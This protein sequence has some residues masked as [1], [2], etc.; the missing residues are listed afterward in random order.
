MQ[1]DNLLQALWEHLGGPDTLQ[2]PALLQ[3]QHLLL[4]GSPAPKHLMHQAGRRG[5]SSEKGDRALPRLGTYL[6]FSQEATWPFTVPRRVTG[7]FQKQPR[8]M[9]R[10][11]KGRRVREAGRTRVL[12]M[13]YLLG[14][15]LPVFPG[16]PVPCNPDHLRKQRPHCTETLY[17]FPRFPS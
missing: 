15:R 10:A 16:V 12:S 1:G 2:G 7:M 8:T 3:W 14:A 4:P 11:Q 13:D 17:D 6:L 9:D 5:A